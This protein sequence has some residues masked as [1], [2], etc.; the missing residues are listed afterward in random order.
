MIEADWTSLLPPFMALLVAVVTRSIFPALFIGIWTGAWLTVGGGF[1]NIAISF[2]NVFDQNIVD[3]LYDRNRLMVIC[4]TLMIGGFIT[5]L[6]A[7]GG[8]RGIL[9]AVKGFTNSPK[10]GQVATSSLGFI[11]FFDGIAGALLIGKTMQPVPDRLKISREKLAYIVDSTSAPM[12][13]IAF[14]TSWI[15]YEISLIQGVGE[16]LPGFPENAYAIFLQSLKYSFYPILTI[17]LVWTISHTGKDFGPM[18]KAE[19]KA[20]KS[21]IEA[22][23]EQKDNTENSYVLNAA[24]PIAV[25]LIS[26]GTVLWTSGTGDSFQQRMATADSFKALMWS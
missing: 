8:M 7:N 15:G 5:L 23:S 22:S 13:S 16:T 20:R 1:S 12:A 19:R 17:I 21:T 26:L 18:L 3:A 11:F 14:A 9:N 6:S 4:F 10:S 2:V 25:L 24:L